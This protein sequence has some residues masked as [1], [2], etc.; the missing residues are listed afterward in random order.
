MPLLNKRTSPF[1]SEQKNKW[2]SKEVLLDRHMLH[3]FLHAEFT[4]C[5]SDKNDS[6]SFKRT[7]LWNSKRYKEILLQVSETSKNNYLN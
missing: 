6:E 1:V 3:V 5:K 4:V 2:T 7:Y